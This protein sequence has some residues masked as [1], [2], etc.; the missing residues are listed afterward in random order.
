METKTNLNPQFLGAVANVLHEYGKQ[1]TMNRSLAALQSRLNCSPQMAKAAV[2]QL[3]KADGLSIDV[4]EQ[5]R[6]W[7]GLNGKTVITQQAPDLPKTVSSTPTFTA[8]QFIKVKYKKYNP[9]QMAKVFNIYL[10]CKGDLAATIR[11]SGIPNGGVRSIIYSHWSFIPSELYPM[12]THSYKARWAMEGKPNRYQRR[13]SQPEPS[14][15]I[16]KTKRHGPNSKR[17]TRVELESLRQDLENLRRSA[18]GTTTIDSEVSGRLERALEAHLRRIIHIEEA[19][20]SLGVATP[21]SRPFPNPLRPVL[22][23]MWAAGRGLVKGE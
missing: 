8:L 12:L 13:Q 2:K 17:V 20:T 9:E 4:A 15:I 5:W 1:P 21:S 19:L 3:L 22:R 10:A 14:S 16:F 11:E 6:G 7:L 23:R 18:I